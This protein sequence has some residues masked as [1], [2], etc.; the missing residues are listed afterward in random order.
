MLSTITSLSFLLTLFSITITALPQGRPP[1]NPPTN[2]LP[3]LLQ[4]IAGTVTCFPADAP[5]IDADTYARARWVASSILEREWPR[6][7]GQA[8]GAANVPV[9][10]ALFRFSMWKGER[11][12]FWE[13]YV[14]ADY[15]IDGI[16]G[17]RRQGYVLMGNTGDG[18]QDASACYGRYVGMAIGC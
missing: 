3:P 13:E 14:A 7:G 8:V 2:V 9:D 18:A 6:A 5:L 4:P 17:S 10:N 11:R 15:W 1:V 12:P 16:C